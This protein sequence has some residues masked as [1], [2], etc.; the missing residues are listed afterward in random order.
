MATE[1]QSVTEQPIPEQHSSG[2]GV[3]EFNGQM[4]LLTWVAFSIAALLL[5][6]LLWKPILNFVEARETEIK[7]A[8]DDAQKA[9][10]SAAEADV[11]AEKTIEQAK[12]EARK[13]ADEQ[14]AAARQLIAK[15]EEDAREAI[16]QRKKA[17]EAQLQTERE[18]AL[19]RLNESA[20]AEI[21]GALER[22]LPGMLTDKQRQDYQEKIAADIRFN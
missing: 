10:Q 21:A 6:K 17:A 18:D 3:L 16:A 4:V 19:R 1:T 9:R 11:A 5:A 2:G 22:M 13:L 8:L 20:G 12:F 7:D 14:A 15:M